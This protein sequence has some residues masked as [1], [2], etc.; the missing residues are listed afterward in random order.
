MSGSDCD[1]GEYFGNSVAVS[2]NWMLVG[3]KND[4]DYQGSVYV[5]KYNVLNQSW[6]EIDKLTAGNSEVI[7]SFGTSVGISDTLPLLEVLVILVRTVVK[8]HIFL[9]ISTMKQMEMKQT[10]LVVY[11]II[12]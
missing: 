8:V 12:N 2:G 7:S 11:V 10:G 9:N 5:F 3:C 4:D 1:A 6:Q